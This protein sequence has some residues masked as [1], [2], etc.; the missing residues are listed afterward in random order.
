MVKE[1]KIAKVKELSTLLS[2][3]RNYIFTNYQGLTVREMQDLKKQLREHKVVYKVVKN[4]YFRI[5]MKENNRPEVDETVW[6][7]P[8][9]V[10][11]VPP[12]ADVSRAVKILTTF[13]KTSNKLA[14]KS[15][16]IDD[17]VYG[18][19][20]LAA[21]AELPPREVLIARVLGAM[22]APLSRLHGVL[23]GQILKLLLV[24]KQ[25]QSK[26]ESQ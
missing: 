6:N 25:I 12:D 23:N 20:E 9:G 2:R 1:H 19:K 16:I 22:K 26:K 24:L 5:A 17:R 15:S 7:N 13:V 11:F 8:L 14:I 4:T 21:I 10:V 3:Y 18:L